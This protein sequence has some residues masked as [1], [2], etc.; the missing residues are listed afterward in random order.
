MEKRGVS[1]REKEL[2]SRRIM[3]IKE[4]EDKEIWENFLA[5]NRKETFLQSWNWGE[6]NKLMGNKIWRLGIYD[7]GKLVSVSLVVKA[8]A[9]RGTFLMIQHGPNIPN[10]KFQAPNSKY[11]ILNVLLEKLKK[12]AKEEKATFI[13]AAPLF[14]RNEENKRLFQDLGFRKAPMHINAYEATWKL[15]LTPT[16][17][18]LLKNMRKTTRYLIRQAQKNPNIEVFRREKIEDVDIFYQI[19][20]EV[21]RFQKFTPFS[22]EYL[23][24]EFSVFL[25][26]NQVSLFF[27]K[28]RDEIV[29]AAFIIFW[30]NIGFYHHAALL[31]KY[32]KIP[33]AYLLQ[34]EAIKEAKKR[35]CSS[36]DFWGYV[37][38]RETPKHP[39]VGPTFFKMGFGGKIYKYVKTQDLPLSKKYFL[40]YIFEKLRKIKRGL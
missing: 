7:Q 30:S 13:R 36:Y 35:G 3:E 5:G 22:L 37:D 24:N 33:I 34:W 20:Q 16:E 40:T 4:V 19:Y 25:P 31:P 2:N 27:G 11:Q 26:D 21:G 17:E 29:A 32:H 8:Q 38:P 6:F 18:E 14:E 39:W 1:E 10:T 28:Y 15:D 23:K 12:I 9:K